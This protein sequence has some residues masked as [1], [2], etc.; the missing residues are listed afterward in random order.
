MN[1]NIFCLQSV[2]LAQWWIKWQHCSLKWLSDSWSGHSEYHQCR[3]PFVDFI[4]T[5]LWVAFSFDKCVLWSTVE[6]HLEFRSGLFLTCQ[7][8]FN[9]NIASISYLDF[10]MMICSFWCFNFQTKFSTYVTMVILWANLQLGLEWF[11]KVWNSWGWT[12]GK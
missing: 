4:T 7:H 2:L 1:K 5:S 9:F 8:Y 6:W 11:Q 3:A 10:S 12:E